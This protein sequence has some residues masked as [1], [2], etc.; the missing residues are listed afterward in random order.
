MAPDWAEAA[1]HR[2]ENGDHTMPMTT[3]DYL[4]LADER[5]A[6]AADRDEPGDILAVST[7]AQVSAIQAVAVAI[8]RLAE[9]VEN[10]RT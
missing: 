9:A 10:P 4:N 6:V 5:V 1:P 7:V 3:S 2:T 8:D